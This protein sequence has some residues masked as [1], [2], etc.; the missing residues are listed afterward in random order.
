MSASARKFFQPQPVSAG[1]EQQIDHA[2][3]GQEVVGNNEVLEILNRGASAH[4]LETGPDVEAEYA[5]QGQEDNRNSIDQDGF[6]T[7]CAEQIHGKADDIFEYG[8]NRGLGGK[9]HEDEEQNTE[10]PS[11]DHLVEDVGQSDE[12]QS[13]SLSGSTPNAKQDGKIISPARKATSVSRRQ[14]LIVSPVRVWSLPM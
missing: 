12:H 3:Q 14:I 9:R 7:G 6:F 4:R 2:A 1:T 11:A 5:G 13:G 8:N 10:N